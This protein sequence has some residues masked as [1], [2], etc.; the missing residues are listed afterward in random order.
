MAD[1][2]WDRYL[3]RSDRGRGDD[4]VARNH[5]A[6]R[7]G[8]DSTQHESDGRVSRHW[9]SRFSR[10]TR[11]HSGAGRDHCQHDRPETH[12]SKTSRSWCRRCVRRDIDHL[13]HRGT[14][15]RFTKRQH[16]RAR[17]A[18]RDRI[19]RRRR[20]ARDH[21]LVLSQN[22]L[23]WLDSRAQSPPQ[24]FARERTRQRSGETL[25]ALGIDPARI[26]FALSRRI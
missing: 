10:R 9:H 8:S 1:H 5:G 24:K 14:R 6:R 20:A 25:A 16:A 23:G 21:E 4:R 18:S 13:V 19:T 3:R 26:H 11:M 15:C 22:L 7:A 12:A 2:F 17:F